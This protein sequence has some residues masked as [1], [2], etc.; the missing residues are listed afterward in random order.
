MER[1]SKGA[2]INDVRIL[3][4]GGGSRNSDIFGHGGEGGSKKFGRP[5]SK[6][7]FAAVYWYF[8]KKFGDYFFLL[9]LV[10]LLRWAN[11]DN[12]RRARYK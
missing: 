8:L 7:Q 3:G 4:G 10:A 5:N 6:S 1:L 11:L 12:Q 2:S 9:Y